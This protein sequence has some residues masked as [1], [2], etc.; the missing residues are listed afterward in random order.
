MSNDELYEA[1]LSA[2]NKLLSDTTVTEDITRANLEALKDE[3]DVM[4]AGLD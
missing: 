3:I 1:A 2:V 4:L